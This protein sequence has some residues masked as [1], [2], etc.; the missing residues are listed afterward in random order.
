MA[1]TNGPSRT[2]TTSW[3]RTRAQAER[4]LPREC[5]DNHRGPCAGNLELDHR[6]PHAEGGADTLD[7]LQWLCKRHHAM[8]SQREAARGKAR[9]T[10]R[11]HF[12]AETHP[13]LI[14]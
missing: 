10:S 5:G 13:G 6:T 1:W 7:N 3:A 4:E 14:E 11:G 9:R 8:K 12:D 2:S